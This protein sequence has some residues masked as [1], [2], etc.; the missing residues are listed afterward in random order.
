MVA[1]EQADVVVVGGGPAGSSTAVWLAR[2]GLNVTLLDKA[3]FPREKA[4]AEYCSPGVV[5]ALED[6]GA[7][8]RV[9]LRDHR[10]L[11]AMDVVAR[12]QAIPLLF[13]SDRPDS[14]PAL[15]IK[16][17]ILD[18]ELINLA[19]DT[20][21]EVEQGV[22]VSHPITEG[23]RV[24]GVVCK[25]GSRE[26]SIRARFVVAADGLHSTIA[27]TLG[28]DRTVRWPRRLGLVARFDGLPNPV[29]TGQMH[30]G[31]GIYCGL[32]PVT[33]TEVNVSLVVPMGAKHRGIPTGQFYD[34]T[35]KLL[36]GIRDVLGDAERITRVRG[37]GPMGKRV[38]KPSG[39]GYLLVGD[40][41]G[42]VGVAGRAPALVELAALAHVSGL[43]R[44]FRARV[45]HGGDE[46]GDREEGEPAEQGAPGPARHDARP[47]S[48]P[49]SHR[50]PVREFRWPETSTTPAKGCHDISGLLG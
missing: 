7:L 3:R 22:R 19:A 5:D 43:G 2:A 35:V 41:A 40:A 17:S 25:S 48:T 13:T 16:R 30:I 31:D 4:C 21:V 32:S 9:K 46:P 45:R 14:N 49:T 39:R 15:G 26:R 11:G 12:E 18:E 50:C 10:E 20:G 37:L 29:H 27:R 23:G 33:P 24:N 42:V 28:L 44:P 34:E 1:T 38:R 6:L 36:P 8:E 47:P